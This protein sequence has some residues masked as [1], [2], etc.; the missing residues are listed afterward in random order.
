MSKTIAVIQGC[1][2]YEAADGRCWMTA[3]ADI[4]CDGVDDGGSPNNEYHDPYYQPDTSLHNNGQAL[5]ALTER[6]MVLPPAA[7]NGVKGV[8]LGCQCRVHY[9][10]TGI[11]KDGVVGDVG[12]SSKVGELSVAFAQGLGMPHNPN[13][14]GE[15]SFAMV[16]YEWWPGVPA[17]VDGVHYHLQPK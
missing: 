6:Y 4:D 17:F 16:V 15:S 3:D 10:Q 5:N 14:G 1:P 11:I 8:V 2:I 7:I 9:L 12:P 13:T